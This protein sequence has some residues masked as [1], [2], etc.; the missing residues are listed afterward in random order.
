[1]N[2]AD[3]LEGIHVLGSMLMMIHLKSDH[4]EE[5]NGKGVRHLVEELRA[6]IQIERVK[7]K[8][9]KKEGNDLNR[10]VVLG[11]LLDSGGRLQ[12]VRRVRQCAHSI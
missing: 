3:A 10:R 5:Q 2:P 4:I 12:M 11:Q 6:H 9:K 8:E 1:M 7:E